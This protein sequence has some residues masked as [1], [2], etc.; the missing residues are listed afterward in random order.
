M[1]SNSL[2]CTFQFV[3]LIG[4]LCSKTIPSWLKSLS[5]FF[6]ETGDWFTGDDITIADFVLY[7]RLYVISLLS[8]GCIDSFDKLKLFMKRFEEL[9]AI[10]SYINSPEVKALKCNNKM[11]AWQG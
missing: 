10:A 1:L 2:Q 11:A 7:E 4:E 6:P 8:P 5:D 9:P 3:E